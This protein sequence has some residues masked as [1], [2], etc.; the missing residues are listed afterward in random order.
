MSKGLWVGYN[1]YVLMV[2]F[3]QAAGGLVRNNILVFRYII[4]AC[5]II[6]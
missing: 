6:H 1:E 4:Y 2:I 3:L 5:R